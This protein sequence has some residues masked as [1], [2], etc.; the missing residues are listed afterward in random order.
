MGKAMAVLRDN[1]AGANNIDIYCLAKA[2]QL[3]L[4]RCSLQFKSELLTHLNAKKMMTDEI[5]IVDA[6]IRTLDLNCNIMIDASDK[7]Q[8]SA[9]K[10]RAV[11]G[12]LSYFDV[13]NREFGETLSLSRLQNHMHEVL[14]VRYFRVDNFPGDI[15][16]NIN[17]IIQL[18]N[19]E[20]TMDLI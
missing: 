12:L 16:A 11:D 4:E 1:G 3:Q 7:Y 9:I 10:Q 8:K 5:T 17:E 19:F 2:S 14:G 15:Q 20:I 13:A 6:V 18:N